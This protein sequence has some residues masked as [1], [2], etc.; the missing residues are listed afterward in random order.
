MSCLRCQH[1]SLRPIFVTVLSKRGSRNLC[2]CVRETPCLWIKFFS[3]SCVCLSGLL[4]DKPRKK[5]PKTIYTGRFLCRDEPSPLNLPKTWHSVAD[6]LITLCI[7][8][9]SNPAKLHFISVYLYFFR[10]AAVIGERR[11]DSWL[12]EFF[13]FVVSNIWGRYKQTVK[14]VIVT[15]VGGRYTTVFYLAISAQWEAPTYLCIW[16]LKSFI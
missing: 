9:I 11:R 4:G 7:C 8:L 10:S 6:E 15:E 5:R 1:V 3:L 14:H 2:V 16:A 12:V 13:C